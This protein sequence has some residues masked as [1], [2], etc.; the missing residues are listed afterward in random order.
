MKGTNEAAIDAAKENAEEEDDDEEEVL[1]EDEILERDAV[2]YEHIQFKQVSVGLDI[3]CGIT[4]KHSDLRCWGASPFKFMRGPFRQVSV[5][6]AGI[7]AIVGDSTGD[8]SE[9]ADPSLADSVMCWGYAGIL[10]RSKMPF[11]PNSLNM[12]AAGS[13]SADGIEKA[14]YDQIS[15]GPFIVCGVTLDS[16]LVCGSHGHFS[17]SDLLKPG[18]LTVA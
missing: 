7:C 9:L 10:F 1:T 6:D 2:E 13:G 14:G 16:E 4:L 17:D 5:G 3:A 15:V 11:P 12:A 8:N 18:F